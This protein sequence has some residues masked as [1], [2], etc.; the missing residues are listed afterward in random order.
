MLQFSS[1]LEINSESWPLSFI[2]SLSSSS[3][4]GTSALSLVV[5]DKKQGLFMLLCEVLHVHLVTKFKNVC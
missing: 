1:F 3:L 5:R 2:F 4:K